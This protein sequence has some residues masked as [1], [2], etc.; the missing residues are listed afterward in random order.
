MLIR[1]LSDIIMRFKDPRIRLV[2][3]VDT[4]LSKDLRYAKVFVSVIG[5]PEER[6][7]AMAALEN[8]LG[9]IRSQLAR[10]IELRVV[11]E[12]H[13]VYDHTSERAARLTALIDSL[14]P[15]SRA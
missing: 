7:A 4:E 10:R 14:N 15:D 3:V 9:Y 1:E 6:Q 12:I 8:G 5:S 13:V 2:T 11:P